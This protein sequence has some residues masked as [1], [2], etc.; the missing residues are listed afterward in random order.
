LTLTCLGLLCSSACA[1]ATPARAPTLQR[2]GPASSGLY[3]TFTPRD[4]ALGDVARTDG[5]L[6]RRPVD[7]DAYLEPVVARSEAAARTQ[8]SSLRRQSERPSPSTAAPPAKAVPEAAP[9]PTASD[10]ERYAARERRSGKQQQ[11]RGG[12]VIVI[13]ATTLIVILLV[14]ILVLLLT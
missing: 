5:G 7:L 12:D 11:Y 2:P 3:T 13:S 14:V 9:S 8:R 4:L 6:A 10:V 1:G